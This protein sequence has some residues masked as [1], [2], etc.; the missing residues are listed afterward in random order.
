MFHKALFFLKKVYNEACGI[1]IDFKMVAFKKFT[2]ILLSN[3]TV[4]VKT[5]R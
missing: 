3:V 4:F 2:S 5:L 1:K